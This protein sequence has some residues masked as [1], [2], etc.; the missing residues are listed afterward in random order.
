MPT[1]PE[2]P[3][4]QSITVEEITAPTKYQIH[5]EELG[6]GFSVEGQMVRV[7]ATNFPS[8]LDFGTVFELQKL[9]TKVAEVCVKV[10]EEHQVVKDEKTK[11]F[12][13]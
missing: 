10:T 4:P 7:H 2:S 6:I 13:G 11:M 5:H 8:E 3:I 12:G 1:S 9:F